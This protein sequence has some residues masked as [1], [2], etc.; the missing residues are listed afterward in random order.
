[1]ANTDLTA[2]NIAKEIG[3]IPSE[4]FVLAAVGS[5]VGSLL[6]RGSD[7]NQD[8]NF[9]GHWAPTFIGLGIYVKLMHLTGNRD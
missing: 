3:K 8:A 9:V 2:V 4:W 7:K 1:M 5:I 6:L